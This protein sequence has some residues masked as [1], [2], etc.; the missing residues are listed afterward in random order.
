[1]QELEFGDYYPLNEVG[2]ELRRIK[3]FG[4]YWGGINYEKVIRRYTIRKAF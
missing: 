4:A 1:M 2:K 3:W